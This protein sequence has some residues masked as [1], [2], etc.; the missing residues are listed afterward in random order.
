MRSL[1]SIEV[2]KDGKS[3]VM[4]GGVFGDQVIRTLDAKGKV[5]GLVTVPRCVLCEADGS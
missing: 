4:G 1:T 3:A 2:A 5:T